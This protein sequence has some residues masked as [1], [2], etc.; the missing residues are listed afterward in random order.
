MS[1]IF[2]YDLAGAVD[3]SDKLDFLIV[4]H[5]VAVLVHVISTVGIDLP[6]DFGDAVF[7]VTDMRRKMRIS[8]L[9]PVLIPFLQV[10]ETIPINVIGREL[11]ELLVTVW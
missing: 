5:T 3:G 1:P 10:F 6:P 8:N 11:D 4:G 9:G 2:F 7:I